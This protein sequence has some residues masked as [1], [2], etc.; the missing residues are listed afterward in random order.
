MR[1]GNADQ[2]EQRT[3][4]ANFGDINLPG[5]CVVFSVSKFIQDLKALL[6]LHLPQN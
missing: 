3:I 6:K 5:Q 2:S 4:P 1:D